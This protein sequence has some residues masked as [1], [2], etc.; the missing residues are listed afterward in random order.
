MSV[1][2][3]FH[4]SYGQPENKLTY[5]FLCL[6]EHMPF[7][8]EFCTF[9]TKGK[10]DLSDAPVCGIDTVYSGRETN[11]DGAVELFDVNGQRWKVYIENKTFRRGLDPQQLANHVSIYCGDPHSYL[12]VIT[13]RPSEKHLAESVSPK[14][15]YQSWQ[16][17]AAKLN[18]INRV[19]GAAS[20]HRHT[21]C[22]IREAE[23][24][25]HEYGND[26][27]RTGCIRNGDRIEPMGKAVEFIRAWIRKV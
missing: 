25:I 13:P 16:E 11:P 10:V 22:R 15:I 26:K 21:V 7:G 23:W 6:L 14:I 4:N 2:N 1:T 12:L 3:I 9:L 27:T 17:I 8:K 5:N 18:E 24:R 19:A 20:F